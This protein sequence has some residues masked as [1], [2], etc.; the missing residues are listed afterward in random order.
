MVF[1]FKLAATTD[2]GVSLL[3]LKPHQ[4]EFNRAELALLRRAATTQDGAQRGVV[5]MGVRG[6]TI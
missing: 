2:K 5:H 6:V 4:P 3:N 1:W